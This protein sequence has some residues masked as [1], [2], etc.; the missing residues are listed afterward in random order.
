MAVTVNVP[1][2]PA[3]VGDGKPVTTNWLGTA[4]VI[5]IPD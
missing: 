2:V 1:G 3:V 5:T 4:G